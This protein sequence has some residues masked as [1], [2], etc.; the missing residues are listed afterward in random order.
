MKISNINKVKEMLAAIDEIENFTKYLNPITSK[1][2]IMDASNKSIWT[3]ENAN[4]LSVISE[5][6]E[7]EK[8][9]YYKIL[10]VL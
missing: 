5:V 7:K 4:T 10:E 3:I 9:K 2:A 6:L 8:D 1:I